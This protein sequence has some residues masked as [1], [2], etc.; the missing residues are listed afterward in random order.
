MFFGTLR[1]VEPKSNQPKMK[2]KTSLNKNSMVSKTKVLSNG[3]TF[4]EWVP[5]MPEEKVQIYRLANKTLRFGKI[6]AQPGSSGNYKTKNDFSVVFVPC[7]GQSSD[8]KLLVTKNAVDREFMLTHTPILENPRIREN[9]CPNCKKCPC[10]KLALTGCSEQQQLE[11]ALMIKSLRLITIDGRPYFEGNY[12][13]DEN[14][15]A[16]LRSNR[17]ESLKHMQILERKLKEIS[18]NSLFSNIIELFNKKFQ[19]LFSTGLCLPLTDPS[20][21]AYSHIPRHYIRWS[22]A[23]RIQ[24]ES[25]PVRPI[26]DHS[27]LT[28]ENG[29]EEELAA[30]EIDKS[31]LAAEQLNKHKK[32]RPVSFNQCLLTNVKTHSDLFRSIAVFRVMQLIWLCDIIGFFWHCALPKSV[33]LRQCFWWRPS[34]L[35][36]SDPW[37]EYC[38]RNCLFGAAASPP[39]AEIILHQSALGTIK[40]VTGCKYNISRYAVLNFSYVDN[41]HR[42]EQ[43]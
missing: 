30:S 18:K 15:L 21:A 7:N 19:K 24:S 2:F 10:S 11:K 39:L 25:S 22:Y 43:M 34:G 9:Q 4:T 42:G 8:Y 5:A 31:C 40:H 38:A 27:F 23:A 37:V 6:K 26:T 13:F 33:S 1:S 16:L 32:G 17:N 14:K 41:L 12:N 36:S 3:S 20:L 29:H 28:P 35:G